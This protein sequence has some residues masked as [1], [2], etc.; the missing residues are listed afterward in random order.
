MWVFGY[1]KHDWFGPAVA[2]SA[3][4]LLLALPID[5][6]W[7]YGYTPVNPPPG[8]EL[9]PFD[10]V[11]SIYS[12]HGGT[13]SQVGNDFVNDGGITATRVYDHDGGDEIIHVLMGDETDVD[14]VWTDGTVTVT[15][16]MK[17]A[18]L[19]QS[20]GWNGGGLG[21][22]YIP[23]LNDGDIGG[24]AVEIDIN[25]DFVWGSRPGTPGNYDYWWSRQ[26]MNSDGGKDHMITYFV[27][28]L[29]GAGVDEA[30]WLLFWEDLPCL[31]DED[32]NDFVIEVRA[33]PEPG[34]LLLVGAGL[35]GLAAARRRR[36]RA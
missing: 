28:G 8:V 26:G 5:S 25:G 32:F 13:W 33:V 27:E 11:S 21:N 12:A 14:Q 1:A 34:T 16:E 35:A 22:G 4:A 7:A 29:P 2:L 23:L 20:F 15:A 9:S 3:A 19:D 24:G 36:P 30:I 31:G 6:A 17:F 18:G 10:I